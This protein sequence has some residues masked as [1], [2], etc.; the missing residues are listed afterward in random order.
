[1]IEAD[2]LGRPVAIL[3]LG[4]RVPDQTRA[5]D[6][7]FLFGCPPFQQFAT[8]EKKAEPTRPVIKDQARRPQRVRVLARPSKTMR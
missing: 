4:G 6:P 8:I 1:L 7:G 3:R 5:I 2:A